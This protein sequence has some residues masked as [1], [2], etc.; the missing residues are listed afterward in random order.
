LS[1]EADGGLALSKLFAS[2]PVALLLS[3]E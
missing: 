3:E 2:F 1:P